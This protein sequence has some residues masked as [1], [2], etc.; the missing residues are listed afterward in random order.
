M[1]GYQL[2]KQYFTFAAANPG[3][4]T[5]GMCALFMWLVE[6]NNRSRFT[7]NFFFNAEDAGYACGMQ[8]RKTVWKY[9]VQLEVAG[10]VRVVYK[11]N[12]QER[13]S[14]LSLCLEGSS[15]LSSSGGG[16]SSRWYGGESFDEGSGLLDCRFADAGQSSD[17]T[18]DGQNQAGELSRR[19]PCKP[20]KDGALEEPF[21][22][23]AG[24]DDIMVDDVLSVSG[25][26]VKVG[27][28]EQSCFNPDS[29]SPLKGELRHSN[30]DSLK[31]PHLNPPRQGGLLNGRA[32]LQ[33]ANPTSERNDVATLA[34]SV[35]DKNA[36]VKVA[37]NANK[38]AAVN[39]KSTSIK[40]TI[41]TATATPKPATSRKPAT[42]NKAAKT[43]ATA[44]ATLKSMAR[45]AP[46]PPRR[47]NTASPALAHSYKGLNYPNQKN[48]VNGSR[49]G[50]GGM[51]E[52]DLSEVSRFFTEHG[53]AAGAAAKAWA[54]YRQAN[55]HDVQGRPVLNWQQK[56]RTI[57]FTPENRIIA[58]Q[59]R[60]VQ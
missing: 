59:S 2:T 42:P 35:V 11:S 51:K 20:T 37:V 53:Y 22:G 38:I 47:G 19:Q 23:H 34:K 9:L 13:P 41:A 48:S 28:F 30:P 40:S 14:V 7:Q 25:G 32:K 3:A 57:W 56:C 8:S 4:T 15:C 26:A 49:M 33:V 1:N 36:V 17:D 39:P 45:N 6:V 52:P 29:L 60:F 55:W 16:G 10:L 43:T 12:N 58:T 18:G 44:T 31:Q 54:H 24:D 21:N 46:P 27:G 50:F 5:P